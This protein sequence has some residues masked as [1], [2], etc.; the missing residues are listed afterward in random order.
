MVQERVFLKRGARR[1][2][3]GWPFSNLV[4][5]RLKKSHSRL[6]KNEPGNIP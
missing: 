4:F 3:G 1:G 6:S 2:G 5:E